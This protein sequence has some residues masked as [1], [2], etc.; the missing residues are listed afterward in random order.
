MNGTQQRIGGRCFVSAEG[1]R[2]QSVALQ[3]QPVT[4]RLSR[5]SKQ[6]SRTLLFLWVLLGTG[7]SHG[8]TRIATDQVQVEFD[9]AVPRLTI[10]RQPVG[11]RWI[12]EPLPDSQVAISGIDAISPRE[13]AVKMTIGSQAA[14]W[15]LRLEEKVAEVRCALSM[16]EDTA[17]SGALE[18][19]FAPVLSREDDLVAVPY[20]EG[21][22]LPSKDLARLPAK[23]RGGKKRLECYFKMGPWIGWITARSGLMQY[24]DTDEDA[25]FSLVTDSKTGKA[26]LRLEWDPILGKF[27]RQRQWRYVLIDTP[28]HVKMAKYWRQ[29]AEER[30]FVRTLRQKAT[31]NPAVEK[32]RAAPYITFYKSYKDAKD[33]LHLE[34]FEEMKKNG[35]NHAG[36]LADIGKFSNFSVKERETISAKLRELG[37]ASLGWSNLMVGLVGADGQEGTVEPT[38]KP[39]QLHPLQSWYRKLPALSDF[40][41]NATGEPVAGGGGGFL[42]L[43]KTTTWPEHLEAHLLRA[44]EE[45]VDGFHVDQMFWT[46]RNQTHPIIPENRGFGIFSRGKAGL[47]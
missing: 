23:G 46:L 4:P 13:M 19:P 25:A 27:G 18:F 24:I 42:W 5:L 20:K 39:Y 7:L 12:L 32:L 9:P 41:R 36:V 37:Y 17:L 11:E 47:I 22:L 30:G 34:I 3:L 35:I 21:F 15:N 28:S 33:P 43:L 6:V 10:L 44:R 16:P 40:I 31:E 14:T 26:A 38:R 45:Q 29:R 8:A 1:G 2:R